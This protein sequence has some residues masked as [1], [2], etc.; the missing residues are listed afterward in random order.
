MI[1]SICGK[2]N[3]T[4][5]A[6]FNSYCNP[7]AF[8]IVL[9]SGIKIYLIPMESG[10]AVYVKRS[11]FYE[12]NTTSFEKAV[13]EIIKGTTESRLEK[14]GQSIYDASVML[15]IIYPELF[16]FKKCDATVSTKKENYGQTFFTLNENGKYYLQTFKD[17]ELIKEA[18]LKE[19]YGE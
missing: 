19:L 18:L 10:D 2:G 3:I 6:E 9:Q 13:N 11:K 1:G 15:S 12:H 4:P 7:E 8:D 14:D 17:G 5:Y 16:E